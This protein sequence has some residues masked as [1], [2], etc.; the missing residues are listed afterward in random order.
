MAH[1]GGSSSNDKR[2]NGVI[3]HVYV[4]VKVGSKAVLHTYMMGINY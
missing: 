1:R 4:R 2:Y 3:I